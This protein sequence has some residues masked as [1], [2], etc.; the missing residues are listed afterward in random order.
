MSASVA[1]TRKSWLSHVLIGSALLA[2]TLV[3]SPIAAQAVPKPAAPAP[4]TAAEVTIKLNELATSTEKL[5]EKFN[6]VSAEV[7]RD[8]AIAAFADK[9]TVGGQKALKDARRGLVA[10]LAMQY[11]AASFSHAA[12]LLS[13]KSGQSYVETVQSLNL[14]A[15]HQSEVAR[16]ASAAS[17]AWNK[18]KAHAQTAVAVAV[19]KRT[20]LATQRATLAGHVAEYKT[21]LASL[22]A[23]ER[24]RYFS[25]SSATSAQ[26]ATVTTSNAPAPSPGADGAVKAAM[27]Q[28]GKPYVW[29]AAGPDAFDCSGLTMW[30]WGR[31]GVS[32]PHLAESQ[33]TMGSSVERSQLA[34]GDLVF[35]GSPAHHVAMY[36]GNGMVVQAPTEGDVVKVTP[37]ES[38]MSEYSGARRFG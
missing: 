38:M 2:S 6:K 4:K 36:I 24:A 25:A 15:A 17:E 37:L 29:A 23:T 13:S 26:L 3:V 14:L 11:K 30:A 16:V 19:A 21:L 1:L 22:N 33:Q 20:E 31:A 28:L 12:A 35:F 34:P 27:S 7:G 5:S 9:A 32:M 18:A 8:L 10:S